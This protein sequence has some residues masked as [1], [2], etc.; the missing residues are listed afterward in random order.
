MSRLKLVSSEDRPVPEAP[1]KGGDDVHLK[2][3]G[4]LMTVE[5]SDSEFTDTVWF[6]DMGNHIGGKF[7]NCTLKKYERPP[8]PKRVP[9]KPSRR[10]QR[11]TK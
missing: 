8:M 2:S 4:P 10:V 7:L 6:D 5:K 11:K 1:F 9:R 3:G